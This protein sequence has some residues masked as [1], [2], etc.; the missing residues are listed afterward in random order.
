MEAWSIGV[1]PGGIRVE[2][3][4]NRKNGGVVYWG[5]SDSVSDPETLRH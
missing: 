3:L 1:G 2:A 4:T 5:W